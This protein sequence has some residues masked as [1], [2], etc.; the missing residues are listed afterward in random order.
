MKH[1]NRSFIIISLVLSTLV[2]GVILKELENDV[3][4][5]NNQFDFFW[6]AFWTIILTATTVGYGDIYP[7][8]TPGRMTVGVAFIVGV[9]VLTFL[10]SSI[11]SMFEFSTDERSAAHE[12]DQKM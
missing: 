11:N 6:N 10:I 4:I 1:H 2:L 3:N 5:D 9:F 8:T 7:Q 12:F